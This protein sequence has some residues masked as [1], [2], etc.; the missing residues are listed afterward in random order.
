MNLVISE[1]D[2]TYQLKSTT[3]D[4][5]SDCFLLDTG[6]THRIYNKQSLFND[7]IQPIKNITVKGV[8]GESSVEVSGS[9]SFR[10][11]GDDSKSHKIKI[12][13]VLY[14]PYSPMN[15][16]SPQSLSRDQSSNRGMML[17]TYGNESL[18]I[19]DKCSLVK[20][21]PHHPTLTLPILTVN[22]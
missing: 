18:L 2:N 10:I 1:T 21:I 14:V 8:G 9:L 5:D 16:I 17:V 11:T 15:L 12:S 7:S 13:E 22:E 19:W 3:L 6:S 20:T 4:V